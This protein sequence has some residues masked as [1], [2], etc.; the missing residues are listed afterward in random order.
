[1]E[2]SWRDLWSVIDA[3]REGAPEDHAALATLVARARAAWPSIDLDTGALVAFIA[4]RIST[5][6]RDAL[7]RLHAEDVYLA[8]A[9]SRGDPVALAEFDRLFLSQVP[10]Y[11]AHR[12]APALADDVRAML[13]EQLFVTTPE[14]PA[15]ILGYEGKGP[16][17]GWLRTMAVRAAID[18]QR[19]DRR[20]APLEAAAPAA[21]SQLDP[22]LDT[23]KAQ[24]AT[25]FK[26]AFEETL[27]TLPTRQR[28]VLRMY[29]LDQVPMEAIGAVYRVHRT[30]VVRW[31]ADARTAIIEETCRLLRSRL[32]LSEAAVESLLG[33]VQSRVDVSLR[34]LLGG[35]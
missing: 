14:R 30:T 16:L 28:N 5:G 13:G 24:Y 31:I 23:I 19:G 12:S 21:G 3:G 35:S 20:Y 7:A 25:E 1:V 8:C 33:V 6:P 2:A 27:R 26:S 29:F 32:G 34:R 9:C 4:R 18:L 15:R 10:T 17:G 22:E 11:L